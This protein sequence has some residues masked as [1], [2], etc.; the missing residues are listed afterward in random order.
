MGF[1]PS[2]LSWTRVN[3]PPQRSGLSAADED[4][5][6]LLRAANAGHLSGVL[7]ESLRTGFIS[8]IHKKGDQE[9]LANYRPISLLCAD[10][11][12]LSKALFTRLTKVVDKVIG[13]H[14]TA[15]PGRYIHTNTRLVQDLIDFAAS[16]AEINKAK[17]TRID[18]ARA[19]SPRWHLSALIC[20]P[21]YHT[22]ASR[23]EALFAPLSA[24]VDLVPQDQL[25]QLQRNVNLLKR[26]FLNEPCRRMDS[27]QPLETWLRIPRRNNTF[28]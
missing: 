17:C 26:T 6:H 12:L 16:N 13:P 3:C 27:R 21:I 20:R 23:N 8:L 2:F 28:P 19:S 10:A 25:T 7:P 14:Q 15:V 22:S 18:I 4:S 24:L 1:G 11:K 9:D 5:P